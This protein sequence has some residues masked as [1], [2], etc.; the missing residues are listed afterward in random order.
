MLNENI[1]I[2]KNELICL[3]H[4][5]QSTTKLKNNPFNQFSSMLLIILIMLIQNSQQI[6]LGQ[7]DV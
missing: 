6:N 5:I 7:S 1:R 3:N 4:S 2:N